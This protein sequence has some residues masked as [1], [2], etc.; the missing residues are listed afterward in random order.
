M[1]CG[2]I[3]IVSYNYGNRLQNYALQEVLHKRNCEVVT[4]RNIEGIE[5]RFDKLGILK[6]NIKGLLGIFL[7]NNKYIDA[8]RK[9]RFER[10]NQNYIFRMHETNYSFSGL[11]QEEFDVVVVGSDQVWNYSYA[12]PLEYLHFVPVEKRA[13][14]AVSFGTSHFTKEHKNLLKKELHDWRFLSVREKDAAD[15]L[16]DELERSVPQHIDPTLLLEKEEWERIAVKPKISIPEQYVLSYFLGS[17]SHNP[18]HV[19]EYCKEHGYSLIEIGCFAKGK[20]KVIDPCEFVW[21]IQHAKMIATDSF[22]GTVFA[23]LM[24]RPFWVFARREKEKSESMMGRL[25]TLLE[26]LHISERFVEELPKECFCLPDYEKVQMALL[27]ERRKANA[28]LDAVVEIGG[29]LN[30]SNQ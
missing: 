26:L 23:I 15:I 25:Y 29:K 5:S 9:Y 6:R 2:I 27:D 13:M 16:A 20:A 22:H 12:G 24:Q 17:D 18:Q 28:Y 21:L 7:P 10:F 8:R 14:Y 4:I 19:T 1:K 30:D 3:T 11:A